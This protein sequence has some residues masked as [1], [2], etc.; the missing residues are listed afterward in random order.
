MKVA[1]PKTECSIYLV[2][3][4]LLLTQNDFISFIRD[5]LNLCFNKSFTAV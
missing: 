2:I 4:M 1:L 5:M 3:E